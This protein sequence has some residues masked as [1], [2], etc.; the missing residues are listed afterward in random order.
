MRRASVVLGREKPRGCA[1]YQFRIG[2]GDL[3]DRAITEAS[4]GQLQRVGIC[5]ALINQPRVLFGDEPTGAL[6]TATSATILELFHD[7]TPGAYAAES[8]HRRLKDI[9]TLMAARGV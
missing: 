6:N 5:R 2:I 1:T 8:H 9:T 4:G 7:T 3:A